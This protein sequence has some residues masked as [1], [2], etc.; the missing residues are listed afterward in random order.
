MRASRRADR[1]VAEIANA[2]DGRHSFDLHLRHD[3]SASETFA[4][5]HVRRLKAMR[6]AGIGVE[7]RPNGIWIIGRDHL[8]QA[9][10]FEQA[11]V[12]LTPVIIETLS[13]LPV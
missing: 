12:R 4:E 9:A 10:R 1:T 5:T 2:N 3:P 6:Q 13:T 11:Q 8:T 7:R